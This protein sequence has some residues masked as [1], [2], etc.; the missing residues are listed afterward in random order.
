MLIVS[1]VVKQLSGSPAWFPDSQSLF[2]LRSAAAG[3]LQKSGG[4]KKNVLRK[5]TNRF[6][7][8]P[9]E[10]NK[11]EETLMVWTVLAQSKHDRHAKYLS[12]RVKP[13][14]EQLFGCG[15]EVEKH[16]PFCLV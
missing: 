10:I 12:Y 15:V 8:G 11:T 3:H 9:S 1:A 6:T 5:T 7:V 16:K 14:A 4:V 2:G 13:N